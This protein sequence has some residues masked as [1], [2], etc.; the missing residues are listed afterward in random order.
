MEKELGDITTSMHGV[1][2]MSKSCGKTCPER[3]MATIDLNQGFELRVRSKIADI[4]I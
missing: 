2:S 3:F 1:H 4:K